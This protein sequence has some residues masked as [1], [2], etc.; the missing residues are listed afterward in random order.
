MTITSLLEKPSH[1]VKKVKASRRYRAIRSEVL[2]DDL[3]L[4]AF[5]TVQQ[6]YVMLMCLAAYYSHGFG[7]FCQNWWCF[8]TCIF[9]M[10]VLFW[11]FV[12]TERY[13]CIWAWYVVE[14]FWIA[15]CGVQ[16]GSEVIFTCSVAMVV[17]CLMILL[18]L[19]VLLAVNA[20]S[21]KW[22]WSVML[23]FWAAYIATVAS[24]TYTMY[25][26]N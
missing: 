10:L 20:D 21:W 2:I 22:Y 8:S 16:I 7:D 3:K 13:I 5:Y 19:L 6:L 15:S 14:G 17:G 1:K 4:M 24:V 25:A 23:F 9:I 18:G 11:L 12:K 26:N